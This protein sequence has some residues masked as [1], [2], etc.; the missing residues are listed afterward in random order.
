MK[1]AD[2]NHTKLATTS[3]ETN[4]GYSTHPHTHKHTQSCNGGYFKYP[5]DILTSEI[6]CYNTNVT[7]PFHSL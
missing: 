3:F 4:S 1:Y 5:N 7:Q 6:S 2:K